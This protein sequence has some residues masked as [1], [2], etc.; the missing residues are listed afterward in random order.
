MFED[1]EKYLL[2]KELDSLFTKSNLYYFIKLEKI[3]KKYT[4]FRNSLGK[5]KI[6]SKVDL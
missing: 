1:N 5:H 4:V 2:E 6:I 3:K